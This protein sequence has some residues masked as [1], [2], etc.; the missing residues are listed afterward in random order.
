[1]TS[2]EWEKRSTER[3]LKAVRKAGN[4]TIRDLERVTHYNRGPI[5]AWYRALE[6][7]EQRKQVV[8]KWKRMFD[9][10]GDDNLGL[11]RQLVMTPE[12]AS[13][14]GSNDKPEQRDGLKGRSIETS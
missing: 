12:V 13:I 5:D 1:M 14:I 10:D 2:Q 7:L 11:A 9:V 6:R 3:I 8:T 4:I